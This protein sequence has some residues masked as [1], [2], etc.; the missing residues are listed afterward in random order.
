MM[1]VGRDH[2]NLN[3]S[4]GRNEKVWNQNQH[5]S[6]PPPTPV[7]LGSVLIVGPSHISA[8][9]IEISHLALKE[10]DTMWKVN[11]KTITQ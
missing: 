8:Q 4:C 9:K 6:S 3:P 7:R 5:G 10:K 2:P 11:Q 1:K